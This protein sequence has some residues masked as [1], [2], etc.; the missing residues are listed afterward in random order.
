MRHGEREDSGVTSWNLH[1]KYI[2]L[3]KK[4]RL[5][6]GAMFDFI[7]FRKAPKDDHD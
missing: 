3:K 4:K 7:F 2:L 5:Y 6:S 1:K